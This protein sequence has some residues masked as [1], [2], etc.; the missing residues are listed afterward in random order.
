VG[1]IKIAEIGYDRP[2]FDR[3]RLRFARIAGAS[4]PPG[5]YAEGAGL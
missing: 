3:A 2:G 1:R 5:K 4:V